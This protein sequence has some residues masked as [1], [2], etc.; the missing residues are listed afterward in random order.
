MCNAKKGLVQTSRGQEI[1]GYRVGSH[2]PHS[3]ND[4]FRG[5]FSFSEGTITRVSAIPRWFPQM[6]RF[7]CKFT[8]EPAG[9][10]THFVD[11]LSEALSE[12]SRRRRVL[13]DQVG[14]GRQRHPA[15][16]RPLFKPRRQP[17]ELRTIFS[18]S[19]INC[20]TL[21]NRAREKCNCVLGSPRAGICTAGSTCTVVGP[22]GF[23]IL[24]RVC[25]HVPS[26][27]KS[28]Q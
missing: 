19:S 9:P 2:R 13:R 18:T 3:G 26:E 28:R 10:A 6:R 17:G 5:V 15:Q 23:T 11:F 20:L 14:T 22:P 7:R 1:H 24:E 8:A 21:E 12:E 16:I 25:V 4:E 27:P